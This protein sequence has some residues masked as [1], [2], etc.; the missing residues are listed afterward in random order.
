MS[1]HELGDYDHHPQVL[2]H[3]DET[4]QEEADSVPYQMSWHPDMHYQHHPEAAHHEA[5]EHASSH[6][7]EHH[8]YTAEHQAYWDSQTMPTWEQHHSEYEHPHHASRSYHDYHE[9]S[10]HHQY[11]HGEEMHHQEPDF[12]EIDENLDDSHL[13]NKS[14]ADEDW[15]QQYQS[16]IGELESLK[17]LQ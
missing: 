13:F 3:L 6:Q 2:E 7:P 16:V 8:P 17:T 1:I 14:V 15:M 9:D 11:G 10:P 5:Y 4:N 12:N